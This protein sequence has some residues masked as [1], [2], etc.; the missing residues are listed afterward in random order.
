MTSDRLAERIA[1]R[2][3]E[4]LGNDDVIVEEDIIE[5]LRSEIEG[6]DLLPGF[7][8]LSESALSF[9]RLMRA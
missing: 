1:V 4:R 9:M 3:V 5:F 7:C 6:L 8:P 2:I